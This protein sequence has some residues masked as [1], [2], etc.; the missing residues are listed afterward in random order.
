MDDWKKD[1]LKDFL[2]LLHAH[3]PDSEEVLQYLE[4][5]QWDEDLYTYCRLSRLLKKGF[6]QS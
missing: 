4:D 3:G 6:Q 5:V 2:K 1:R